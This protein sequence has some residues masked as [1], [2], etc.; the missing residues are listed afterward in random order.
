MSP[1]EMND[2]R[3]ARYLSRNPYAGID[4]LEEWDDGENEA[5]FNL[6]KSRTV[7]KLQNQY[8]YVK[9]NDDYGSN[10]PSETIRVFPELL[11]KAKPPGEYSD[12][13]IEK[14]VRRL[15][16]M[17]W[18][19]SKNKV[20]TDPI[21][22]LDP[23]SALEAIGYKYSLE[24]VLGQEQVTGGHIEVAG[25]IDSCEKTVRTSRKLKRDTWAFTTAHEL[26]HAVLHPNMGTLHRDRAMDGA[27]LSREPIERDADRFATFF[28]MPAKLVTSR[29]KEA[30]AT[31]QF[32]LDE[33]TAF[34]LK[35]KP[36]HEVRKGIRSLRDLSLMLA[37]AEQFNGIHFVSLADQFN[38]SAMAMAIRLEEL[39]LV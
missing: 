14:V 3:K 23:G 1:D 24:E 2:L 8:A 17:L 10:G 4:R 38:V 25:I 13:E 37:T 36:M 19:R 9:D 20:N 11:V 27:S 35:R 26:G 39:G 34:A 12:A 5:D 33:A 30:F 22:L 29:F 28:L 15:Q 21:K 16:A 6:R 32:V 7:A 31:E 18:K